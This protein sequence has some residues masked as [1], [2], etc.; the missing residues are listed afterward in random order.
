MVSLSFLNGIFVNIFFYFILLEFVIIMTERYCEL[1][2]VFYSHL[3]TNTYSSNC[4]VL[5]FSE[6]LL[7]LVLYVFT[8]PGIG[9]LTFL[10]HTFASLHS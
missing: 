8:S 4:D 3:A 1:V 7:R 2:F 5:E 9:L 10:R 6:H